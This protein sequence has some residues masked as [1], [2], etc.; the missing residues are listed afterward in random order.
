MSLG[1]RAYNLLRG[2]V[3]TEWERIRDVERDRA[4]RELVDVPLPPVP[5]SAPQTS[6]LAPE[7]QK[8]HARRILGVEP[9]APFDEVRK[10]FVRLNKRSDPARFP[11][12]S[13]EANEAAE[14]QKRV[15]WAYRCLT[16]DMDSTERRFR[17]LEIE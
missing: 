15:N 12:G 2:Y 14:I 4:N 6:D 3:H 8:A 5:S 7:D 17:T 13:S 9:D 1:R 16:D 10:C 11:D